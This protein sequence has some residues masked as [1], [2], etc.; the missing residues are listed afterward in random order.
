MT[1]YSA[2]IETNSTAALGDEVFCR[3]QVQQCK[4]WLLSEGGV[5]LG[6]LKKELLDQLRSK[7]TERFPATGKGSAG[8][9]QEHLYCDS[10]EAPF[11]FLPMSVGP[12]RDASLADH[13]ERR[14]SRLF[15][16]HARSHSGLFHR[17]GVLP[18]TEWRAPQ[19]RT[20]SN[21]QKI[22]ARP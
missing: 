10:G 4:A 15:A 5:V 18:N 9:C 12:F 8:Q 1:A 22:R 20:P 19:D 17:L 3:S 14:N 16:L 6:V 13:N 7:K 2:P 11:A 21:A